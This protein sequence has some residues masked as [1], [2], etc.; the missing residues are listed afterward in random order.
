MQHF[1]SGFGMFCWLILQKHLIALYIRRM[2]MIL[3]FKC[4][5]NSLIQN[6]L[7]SIG[8]TC[9]SIRSLHFSMPHFSLSTTSS[10]FV[11]LSIFIFLSLF[12][13]FVLLIWM[14]FCSAV[15]SWLQM[16]YLNS[17]FGCLRLQCSM[18]IDEALG[19]DR[20][21]LSP[22][23]KILMLV[24][25]CS[26]EWNKNKYYWGIHEINFKRYLWAKNHAIISNK[27]VIN[28]SCM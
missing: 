2:K 5:R 24:A 23:Q 9:D 18:N 13:L 7:V 1:F 16:N 4:Q 11:F 19:L 21:V 14:P 12:C 20:F 26:H 6:Q 22:D 15:V 3:S 8:A 10:S 17:S 27:Q 28:S 25:T